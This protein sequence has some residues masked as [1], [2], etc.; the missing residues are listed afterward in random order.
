MLVPPANISVGRGVVKAGT[1]PGLLLVLLCV[2]NLCIHK[3]NWDGVLS[4]RSGQEEYDT[5]GQDWKNMTPSLPY[6]HKYM[7]SSVPACNTLVTP[8]DLVSLVC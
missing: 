8:M 6:L 1:G 3:F 5:I 4:F 2:R 7:D